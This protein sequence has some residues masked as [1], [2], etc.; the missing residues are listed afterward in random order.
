MHKR[1]VA[2][3][4]NRYCCRGY[5]CLGES[6]RRLWS[7]GSL[8]L[9]RMIVDKWNHISSTYRGISE[10]LKP[11][12]TLEVSGRLGS[13]DLGEN[14]GGGRVVIHCAREEGRTKSAIGGDYEHNHGQE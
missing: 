7:G 13:G 6:D 1:V 8:D 9:N 12:L 4:L 11:A 5:F 10:A 14:R 2:K 3:P